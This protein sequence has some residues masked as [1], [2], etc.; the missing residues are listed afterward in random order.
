MVSAAGIITDSRRNG[1]S[2][3]GSGSSAAQALSPR[4]PVV[5]TK[6][7]PAERA[8]SWRRVSGSMVPSSWLS[9]LRAWCAAVVREQLARGGRQRWLSE[10]LQGPGA[11][12]LVRQHPVVAGAQGVA[13]GVDERG[14]VHV[15][16]P[17]VHP[18]RESRAL[19]LFELD[20]LEVAGDPAEP[21]GQRH[22]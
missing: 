22:V 12:D 14:L 8:R 11:P 16:D 4:P 18:D 2:P 15:C 17:G 19:R 5:S 1:S 13:D 21:G 9:V 10:H 3:A 6:A 20:E 7:A